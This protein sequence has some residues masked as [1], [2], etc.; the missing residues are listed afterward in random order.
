MSL[1][2]FLGEFAVFNMIRNLFSKKRRPGPPPDQQK[3]GY[4]RYADSETRIAE[5]NHEIKD[6]RMHIAEYQGMIDGNHARSIDNYDMDELQD[7]IDEL[8]SQ[9][10]DFDIMS[11]RYDELQDEIDR[12][13]DCLDELE[14]AQDLYDDIHDDIDEL[15]DLYDVLDMFDDRDTLGCCDDLH[16]MCYD[17]DEDW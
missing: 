2:N 11:D 17:R 9:L 12:L 16:D 3:W 6:A 8:E 13:H 5:L 4:S 14:D 15:D 1:W 7:R 10:D